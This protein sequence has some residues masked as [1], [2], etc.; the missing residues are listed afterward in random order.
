MGGDGT[1]TRSGSRHDFEDDSLR[2]P[3]RTKHASTADRAANTVTPMDT[4]GSP[5]TTR[6]S[7]KSATGSNDHLERVAAAFNS[8]LRTSFFTRL[9]IPSARRKNARRLKEGETVPCSHYGLCRHEQYAG[10]GYFFCHCCDL[11]DA[12]VSA[13]NTRAKR[14]SKRFACEASHTSTVAPTDKRD[15]MGWYRTSWTTRRSVTRRKSRS[16]ASVSKVGKLSML[17]SCLFSFDAL[18]TGAIRVE[19][20]TKQLPKQSLG[21]LLNGY[22]AGYSF[23][24]V[25]EPCWKVKT[26][27][28]TTAFPIFSTS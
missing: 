16:S 3:K 2:K 9:L 27:F 20:V 22:S 26:W 7:K 1:K 15:A 12:E 19:R 6:G 17:L 24:V 4:C 23:S 11:W 21:L 14:D 25:D 18:S 13:G 10:Q 8:P 28:A 5:P